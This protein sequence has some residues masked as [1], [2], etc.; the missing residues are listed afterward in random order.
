VQLVGRMYG[1]QT[2]LSLAG[3]LE[4]AHPWRAHTPAVW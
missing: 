1:E 4:Q 3:Q 2:L